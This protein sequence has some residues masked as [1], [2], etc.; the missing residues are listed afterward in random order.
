[1]AKY[2]VAIVM[3]TAIYRNVE[4]SSPFEAIEKA[5]AGDDREIGQ[6]SKV[7]GGAREPLY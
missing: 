5:R 7:T 4:A 1:M 2:T 6:Q 3:T